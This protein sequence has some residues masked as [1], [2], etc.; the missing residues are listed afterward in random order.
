MVA[1]V[2]E[3][4]LHPWR[5]VRELG[6]GAM[7]AVYEAV[8][9]H[10][11][12]RRA[13]KLLLAASPEAL[14]PDGLARFAREAEVAARLA[15]PNL[16]RVHGWRTEPWP[17]YLLLDLLPGGTLQERLVR[18]PLPPEEA[19][20][21][22]EQLADGLAHAHAQGV[23]HRDLKPGNV[24]FD[25]RG[26]P[27]INDF[28]LARDLIG[29]DGLTRTGELI[30][31]PVYMSP[32]QALDS[33]RADMRSDV[34]G[35]GAVLY[36][37]LT[38][39][40]PIHGVT[41]LIEAV[42]AITH[43][44]VDPPSRVVPGVPPAL[45]AVCL[46]ALEKDPADRWPSALAFRDALREA[47]V[48]SPATDRHR[49]PGRPAQI[50]GLVA[51]WLAVA[52][53]TAA[54]VLWGL[55]QEV[56][57]EESASAPPLA[58]VAAATTAAGTAGPASGELA[59]LLS[60]RA[61]GSWPDLVHTH[62]WRDSGS[63]DQ[64]W[65][66]IAFEVRPEGRDRLLLHPRRV[67]LLRLAGG[68]SVAYDTNPTARMS[69]PG[70]LPVVEEAIRDLLEEASLTLGLEADGAVSVN[71][72]GRWKGCFTRLGAALRIP[73]LGSW[74]ERQ[75]EEGLQR[76]W[77]GSASL[78]PVSDE[79]GFPL[80]ARG[81]GWAAWESPG[82][83]EG[84]ARA[85]LVLA[86]TRTNYAWGGEKRDNKP[87][88]D[89]AESWS[90]WRGHLAAANATRGLLL[91]PGGE[92]FFIPEARFLLPA[93]DRAPCVDP[94]GETIPMEQVR[95]ARP[96]VAH[97][98][99]WGPALAVLPPG[100]RWLVVARRGDWTALAWGGGVAWVWSHALLPAEGPLAR[101]STR[102]DPVFLMDERG[103]E[104]GQLE[105][106][107]VVA[108]DRVAG[109]DVWVWFDERVLKIQRGTG[110][111]PWWEPR[112]PTSTPPR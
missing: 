14:D 81:R 108:L 69:A 78:H 18:G 83:V 101:V 94:D 24:L 5:R 70:S 99:P 49:R 110:D 51:L 82:G 77:A 54:G 55:G 111:Y 71:T 92:L 28:G 23:V 9:A 97:A 35:L 65:V 6:R 7:G 47:A 96:A 98:W 2:R 88:H 42:E 4:V 76:T 15:H 104:A 39:R 8:H 29:V 30:G 63:A 75:G 45:E 12:E 16:A 61:D 44:P 56:P 46:R 87:Y 62:G 10:T 19:R 11:G 48:R 31:T 26:R 90:M 1:H 95:A 109:E 25:A 13:L 105:R 60:P 66:S 53:A 57:A 103:V 22:A 68:A 52:G 21:I 74:A 38:G 73:A 85:D 32:E 106:R 72:V 91:V 102:R 20:W 93:P 59:P 3:E 107:A 40:P 50:A 27:R 17:P 58:P 89:V 100:G 36:A 86:W 79:D 37:S 112:P 33:K 84:L 41:T 80:G 64:A 67:R 34:Y 43:K